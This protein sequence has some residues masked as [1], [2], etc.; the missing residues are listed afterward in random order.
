MKR[1]VRDIL[2]CAGSH[3]DIP[4]RQL[5]LDRKEYGSKGQPLNSTLVPP[6]ITPSG[7]IIVR[8]GCH[9][10]Y[11]VHSYSC[12]PP[13]ALALAFYVGIRIDDI[14]VPGTR[15]QRDTRTS[16]PVKCTRR[17]VYTGCE[18]GKI[19]LQQKFF[20]KIEKTSINFFKTTRK[21]TTTKYTKNL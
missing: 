2:D 15:T 18:S 4:T 13:Y 17:C 19:N 10:Q 3:R 20:K 11:C 7:E 6:C 16:V 12:P 14:H 9:T 21:R 8:A 5:Y 1:A